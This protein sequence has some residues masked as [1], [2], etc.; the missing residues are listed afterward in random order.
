[1]D[2][3]KIFEILFQS[4]HLHSFS[5]AFSRIQAILNLRKP[6]VKFID[7]GPSNKIQPFNFL[8][9][10]TLTKTQDIN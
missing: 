6:P 4:K 7:S 3:A 10:K 8:M 9:P 1:M 5:A 2:A